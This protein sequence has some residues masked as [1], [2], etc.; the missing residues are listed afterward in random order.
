[1]TKRVLLTGNRGKIGAVT[2]RL[3]RSRG[4]DVVGYDRVGGQRLEDQRA[5]ERAVLG[6]D[7]VAHLAAIPHNHDDTKALMATNVTGTWNVLNAAARA[8]VERVVFMSSVNALG[9]FLGEAQPDYLPID[10]D[11]PARPHSPYGLSKLLA[12]DVCRYFT[13]N[14]GLTTLCLRPPAVLAADDYR[15]I[16]TKRRRR[17]ATEWTPYWEYG[18]F[19]DVPDCAEAVVLALEAGVTGHHRLLLCADDIASTSNS[20]ELANRLLP[21]V[22]WRAGIDYD[23]SPRAAL[24]DSRR[25]RE[26]LGWQPKKRWSNAEAEFAAAEA[27]PVRRAVYGLKTA[28]RLLLRRD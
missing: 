10:D 13:E 20:C 5:L 4:W 11:H 22:Q 12:E 1:M 17:P 8:G 18:A 3:L 6:C 25:A 15:R 27:R 7:A 16:L 23:A 14:H 2:E 21:G 26:L 28:G 9:V 19:V 24:V